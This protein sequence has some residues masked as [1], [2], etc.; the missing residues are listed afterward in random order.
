MPARFLARNV[1]CRESPAESID[2]QRRIVESHGRHQHAEQRQRRQLHHQD[3]HCRTRTGEPAHAITISL[4]LAQDFAAYVH[5]FQPDDDSGPDVRPIQFDDSA[6][7]VV[8][9]AAPS[10]SPARRG[11]RSARNACSV[12][13]PRSRPEIPASDVVMNIS[14]PGRPCRAATAGRSAI[15]L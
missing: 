9:Y 2:C 12:H 5:D 3:Q 6:G 10:R 7:R 15:W 8:F 13:R 4:T 1:F 11:C 14:T